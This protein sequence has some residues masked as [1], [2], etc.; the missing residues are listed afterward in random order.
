MKFD[1]FKHHR[2]SVRL[3]GYDYSQAGAYFVTICT[4]RRQLFFDDPTIKQFAKECWLAIPEHAPGVELDEWVVMPNHLHGIIFI[5]VGRGVQLNAPTHTPR[6]RTDPYSVISPKRNTLSVIVR[7][8]KA[9]V[10]T[11]C[12]EIERNDFAWQ[13]N[14]YEHIIRDERALRAIREY[15]R[16]NPLKWP[17]DLDN[18]KNFSKHPP[19]NTVDDYLH[20][21][22]GAF[23]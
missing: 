2:R 19:P 17:L 9:A 8:Y 3:R 23:S 22:T 14:Y 12:R 11:A 1:P 18:P 21:A 15:I 5:G 7:T 16:N 6:G 10:T 20:D 4:H 13:R